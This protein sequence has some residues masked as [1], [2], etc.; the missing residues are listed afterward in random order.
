MGQQQGG[1][2]QGGQPLHTWSIDK[3]G[4]CNEEFQ[5]YTQGCDR[6]SKFTKKMGQEQGGEGQGEI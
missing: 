6:Q 3:T 5:V 1:E 4:M 2:G